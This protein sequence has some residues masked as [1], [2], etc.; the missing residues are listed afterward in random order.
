LKTKYTESEIKYSYKY[1]TE[2]KFRAFKHKNIYKNSKSYGIPQGAGI[3]SV[4]SNIYL[5]DF[6]EKIH[7]YV[8]AQ[9]GIYRRYCD[10]IIIVISIEGDVQGYND[11]FQQRIVEDIKE[12]IPNLVI[13]PKK[14]GCYFCNNNLVRSFNLYKNL[15]KK[16]I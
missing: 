9:K 3:S 8:N 2:E 5:L 10:D 16:L 12:Q 13:Q 6:D 7:K 11:Q 1:F 15:E 4:C 14:T